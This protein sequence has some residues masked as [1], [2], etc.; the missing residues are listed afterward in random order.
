MATKVFVFGASGHAKVVID[1]LERTPGI[2]VAFAIDDAAAAKGRSLCGYNIIGGRDELLAHRAL[3]AAGIATIGDNAARRDVAAWL[4]AQGFKLARV[5]HPAATL[6]REV[7][8]GDGTVIMAGCVINTDTAVGANVIINTG[9]TIDHDCAIG[10]GVHI[11]PG[12]HLC[13]GVK[14]GAGSLLGAGTTVVP[15]VRIGDNV[16][17]GAGSTVLDHVANGARVAGSPARPLEGAA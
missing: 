12:C 14:V 5:I 3:A 11:A 4:V 9:S 10:D 2:E 1:I 7:T 8:V 17:V 13:G 15:G 16:V 6:A